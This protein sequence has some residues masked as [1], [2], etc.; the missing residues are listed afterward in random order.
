MIYESLWTRLRRRFRRCWDSRDRIL[1]PPSRW[2]R[3]DDEQISS[4][5]G[6]RV[7]GDNPAHAQV[8]DQAGDDE[9]TETDLKCSYVLE[10]FSVSSQSS[11]NFLA[12]LCSFH[13]LMTN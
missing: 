1:S 2:E 11:C 3:V 9:D 7:S 4:R 12:N 5:S 10:I 8:G 6:L 13:H